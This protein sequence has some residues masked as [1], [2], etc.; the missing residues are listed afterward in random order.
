MPNHPN[1]KGS[2]FC[3]SFCRSLRQKLRPNQDSFYLWTSV[4]PAQW[5]SLQGQAK[6]V[7]M[8][9]KQQTSTVKRMVAE[10]ISD[11]PQTTTTSSSRCNSR[12]RYILFVWQ[13]EG[14][15]AEKT[16]RKPCYVWPHFCDSSGLGPP[17]T[18]PG[19]DTWA[20]SSRMIV[21]EYIWMG[22]ESRD[23]GTNQIGRVGA[24]VSREE[25]WAT[26]SGLTI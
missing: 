13:L 24:R 6:K 15:C 11:P 4:V 25:K 20:F 23:F 10:G 3:R 8:Q 19:I 26:N 7:G 16:L 18:F 22:R 5:T 17:I 14:V 12:H 21:K 9:Q 2:C 1:F